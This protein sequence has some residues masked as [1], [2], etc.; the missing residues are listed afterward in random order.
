MRLPPVSLLSEVVAEMVGKRRP[1]RSC[2][3]ARYTAPSIQSLTVRHDR[4]LH[5]CKVINFGLAELIA[6]SSYSALPFTR[7][8]ETPSLS[9]TSNGT[10]L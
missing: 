4:Q 1:D 7:S 5:P 3:L 2:C 8:L 9:D 10:Q 6:L